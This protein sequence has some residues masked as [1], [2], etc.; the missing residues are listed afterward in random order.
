VDLR[1]FEVDPRL[2]DVGPS[3]LVSGLSGYRLRVIGLSLC[4]GDRQIV[5]LAPAFCLSLRVTRRGLF[6]CRIGEL[7]RN[8][9]VTRVTPSVSRLCTN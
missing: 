3:L 8:L 4:D 5:Q 6:G 7:D 1:A 2:L 9:V